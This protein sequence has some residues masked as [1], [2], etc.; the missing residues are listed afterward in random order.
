M[1]NTREI[2]K[3]GLEAFEALGL[4]R[5]IRPGMVDIYSEVLADLPGEVISMVF[6]KLK[7]DF[8]PRFAGQTI[9]P[10][11]VRETAMDIMLGDEWS[12]AFHECVHAASKLDNPI[13][14]TCPNTGALIVAE[15]FHFSSPIVKRAFE[16]FGGVDAF[17][18]VKDGDTTIRAQFRD[19]YKSVRKKAQGSRGA[20]AAI[21]QHK[22]NVAR[23][24]DAPSHPLQIAARV[25]QTRQ[26]IF[27]QQSTPEGT[28]PLAEQIM[29][30]LQSA[31]DVGE[32]QKLMARMLG[33]EKLNF[34]SDDQDDYDYF[35]GKKYAE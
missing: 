15:S 6:S 25:E 23:I 3:R 11:L 34:G 14:T 29:S 35:E 5:E 32:R 19:V 17:K 18:D 30:V 31:G 13:M 4:I 21:A 20:M 22:N 8:Q 12:E 33:I 2:I 27:K 10:A 24:S 7:A 1:L 28:T 26:Q 9:S 16:K